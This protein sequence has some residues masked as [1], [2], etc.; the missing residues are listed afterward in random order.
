MESCT[1]LKGL[2]SF[3]HPCV[4]AGNGGY[5]VERGRLADSA[6]VLGVFSGAGGYMCGDHRCVDGTLP[7]RLRLG[8]LSS[9]V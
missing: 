8:R 4:P 7:G 2:L 5:G 1:S 9:R 6:V 3:Y